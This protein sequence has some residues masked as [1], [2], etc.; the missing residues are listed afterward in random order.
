VKALHDLALRIAKSE[1]ELGTA[2]V[3]PEQQQ[4]KT[5]LPRG[6][7]RVGGEYHR[8]AQEETDSDR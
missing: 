7:P 2:D 1:R 5:F 4:E 3:D 8:P 6:V